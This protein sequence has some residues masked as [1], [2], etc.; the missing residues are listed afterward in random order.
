LRRFIVAT[1]AALA[2]LLVGGPAQAAPAPGA[3][4]IG[5]PYFPDYGNGGY[6]VS[7][8]DIRVRYYPD[9]DRLTG[10]TTILA[11]A[12]QDLNRFNLDFI[13][14][15][16]SVRVNG[17][18]A[19]FVRQGDHEL[20]VTPP[21][22]INRNQLMTIV[23]QY[24]GVPSDYVA[25][26]YTAWTRTEDGALAIGQPE[27]SW[28]W[29]PSNDHPLDKATWDVS[30]LV[31]DGVEVLSNG[32]MPRAPRP[33]LVGWTRWS[34]RSL[35]PGQTYMPFLAI[36]QYEIVQDVAP[37]GQQVI[38][39]YSENLGDYADP[40]RASIE[41][42]AEVVDWESGILGP[43]P[44]EAQGGVVVAPNTIGFALENQTRSTY[45]A[46]FFRRGSDPYVVVHENGHQWFGDSVSLENWDDIW[47]HEGFATYMEWLWSEYTGEGTAQEVFDFTYQFYAPTNP[48][49]NVKPGDPGPANIFHIA[50]YDRGAMA[51]HQMRLAMGDDAFFETL[52]TWVE[53][54][55]Y[56]NGN[57][58]QFQALAEQISGV[59]LDAVFTT[60]LYTAGRP[61][62]PASASASAKAA[63]SAA[64][65]TAAEPKSWAK[66]RALHDE[67]SAS[68]S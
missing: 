56:G 39:A 41:R 14:P 36:G 43:Y 7:H 54:R 13:L 15:T 26:G 50:V 27:I 45:A 46:E 66:L 33:E 51:I 37:N 60:W 44:F 48:F 8:Y 30:V 63:P 3:P 67:L 24:D 10:T 65:R 29:Y 42:T 68:K 16:Q 31:P 6:N 55:K 25:A 58:A 23:V 49:W 59:D 57:I 62:L 17:W 61:T 34:W 52:R 53:S 35:R 20:V 4:G 12:T 40:A 22:V 19:S 47:L 2:V 28:W 1:A 64:A 9:T 38:N 21:R 18:S 5:D 11:R 32:V